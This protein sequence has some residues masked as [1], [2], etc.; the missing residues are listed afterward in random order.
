MTCPGPLPE[1]LQPAS[2]TK[3]TLD[4]A[5]KAALE[6]ARKAA[7]AECAKRECPTSEDPQQ[8]KV[9]AFLEDDVQV[10]AEEA[11]GGQYQ[12]KVIVDGRCQCEAKGATGLPSGESTRCAPDAGKRHITVG[13]TS[14]PYPEEKTGGDIDDGLKKA[15]EEGLKNA[16]KAAQLA[17]DGKDCA[18][19]ECKF[20]ETTSLIDYTFEKGQ[21]IAEIVIRGHCEC[22]SKPVPGAPATITCGPE[23]VSAT[24]LSFNPDPAT[25][26]AEAERRA[27]ALAQLACF[28]QC[29]TKACKYTETEKK[30]EEPADRVAKWT[31]AVE[32]TGKCECK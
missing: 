1:D 8:A 25:A 27:R 15:V 29:G 19:K 26:E 22:Q 30:K 7:A 11:N 6:A 28:G 24:A 4:E 9:C 20:V 2:A 12:A 32:T 10:E 21:F 23:D 17:C 14:K 16:R 5:V 31:I 3:V 13:W 18:T